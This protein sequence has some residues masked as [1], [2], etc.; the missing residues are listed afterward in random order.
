M[1]RRDPDRVW[2]LVRRYQSLADRCPQF[3][4]CEIGVVERFGL[5]FPILAGVV[6]EGTR[7]AMIVAGTHGDEIAGPLALLDFWEDEASHAL[8]QGTR[9]VFMPLINPF[10]FAR[11]IRGNGVVDLNRHFERP[12][13]Q[14]ENK[15]VLD[16]LV[17]Q[18]ADLLVSM[19]EDV[20]SRCFYMYESGVRD[21]AHFARIV[22]DDVAL[23]DS[24]ESHGYAACRGDHVDGNYNRSGL[25]VSNPGSVRASRSGALEPTL[26]R[27]G[28]IRRVVGFETPGMQPLADRI[29]QQQ[30]ALRHV[31]RSF[32]V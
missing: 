30:I 19:H 7:S 28:V 27:H 10:G 23:L 17:R 6:G 16:F 24:I 14:P 1:P 15:I 22:A 20:S 11:G 31:L 2:E 4:L 9:F 26:L 8:T 12:T 5:L 3:E 21:R 29:H 25:V 13:A 18:R 32:L